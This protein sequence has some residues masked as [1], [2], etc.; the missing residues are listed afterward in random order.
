M[1]VNFKNWYTASDT[2]IFWHY[3]VDT[4]AGGPESLG[5]IYNPNCQTVTKC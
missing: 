3:W 5:G 1:G 4:S 2:L